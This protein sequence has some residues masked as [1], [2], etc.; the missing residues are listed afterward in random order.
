MLVLVA[1]RVTGTISMHFRR[2]Y[3][4][5]FLGSHYYKYNICQKKLKPTCCPKISTG[6]IF[7]ILELGLISGETVPLT[8]VIFVSLFTQR[9]LVFSYVSKLKKYKNISEVKHTFLVK[10]TKSY[11]AYS[12]V[13]NYNV[14]AGLPSLRY[15]QQNLI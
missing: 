1:F 3:G 5:Y 8:H 4:K 7:Y 9:F 2:S 11:S 12:R 15:W 13:H 14:M 10:H 6:L